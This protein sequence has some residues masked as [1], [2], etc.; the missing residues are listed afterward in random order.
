MD[1][2]P[3]F[4]GGLDCYSHPPDCAQQY[5]EIIGAGLI[6]RSG[7]AVINETNSTRVFPGVHLPP[8]CESP[9]AAIVPPILQI[10]SGP[11]PSTVALHWFDPPSTREANHRV[12]EDIYL[13]V[14]GLQAT[15]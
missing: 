7:Y 2:G 3:A 9:F 10:S 11:S 13:L 4:A 12:A 6:S 15:A 8:S 1:F 14:S 5:G